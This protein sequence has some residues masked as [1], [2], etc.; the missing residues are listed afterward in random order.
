VL[1]DAARAAALLAY[2]VRA[3]RIDPVGALRSE[4]RK[5]T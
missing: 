1:D 4:E 3:T 2:T 5:Y